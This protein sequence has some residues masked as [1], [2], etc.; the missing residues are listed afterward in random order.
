MT[1]DE[2]I[3]ALIAASPED[4][5]AAVRAIPGAGNHDRVVRYTME[6]RGRV[7]DRIAGLPPDQQAS[8]VKALA[9]YEET[10]GGLGSVTALQHVLRVINDPDHAVFDWVLTNTSSYR[11][12]SGGATSFAELH[13]ERA[14]QSRRWQERQD[15]ERKLEAEAKARKA[16]RAT[17]NL[18][19]AVRRG[20]IKAVRALLGQGASPTVTTPDGVGLAEYARASGRSDIAELLS[21]AFAGSVSQ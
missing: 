13:A 20:D 11:Y 21:S 18:Y 15:D 12:Y 5:Y 19:N 10:V 16:G 1:A 9:V 4:R 8:F 14:W 7:L 3:D 17:Q 2:L 6:L